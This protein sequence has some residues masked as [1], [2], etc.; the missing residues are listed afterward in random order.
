MH[1]ERRNAS[2]STSITMESSELFWASTSTKT[3]TLAHFFLLSPVS[4][5]Q[6]RQTLTSFPK[7]LEPASFTK[8]FVKNDESVLKLLLDEEGFETFRASSRHDTSS[9]VVSFIGKTHAGKSHLGKELLLKGGY[10]VATGLPSPSSGSFASLEPTTGDCRFFQGRNNGKDITILDMEGEDAGDELPSEV[11]ESLSSSTSEK[12]YCAARR[13]ATREH[14]PRLAYAVSDVIVY[15]TT[16]S[17]SQNDVV[18][19]LERIALSCTE[20]VSTGLL[21]ALVVVQNKQPG[22]DVEEWLQQDPD[23]TILL[24]SWLRTH[25]GETHIKPFFSA[26]KVL[27]ISAGGKRDK[28]LYDEASGKFCKVVEELLDQRTSIRSSRSLVLTP[29]I[30]IHMFSNIVHSFHVAKGLNVD[31]FYLNCILLD[32]G[33]HASLLEKVV[34]LHTIVDSRAKSKE[35]REFLCCSLALFLAEHV[36]EGRASLPNLQAHSVKIVDQ[37]IEKSWTRFMKYVWDGWPCLAVRDGSERCSRNRALHDPNNH[38]PEAFVAV[39]TDNWIVSV[40]KRGIRAV[41]NAFVSWPGAFLSEDFESVEAMSSWCLETYFLPTLALAKRD[42]VFDKHSINLQRIVLFE[43]LSAAKDRL[44][45]MDMGLGKMCLFCLKPNSESLVCH[46]RVCVDCREGFLK[47]NDEC[48]C[49][50]CIVIDRSSV[51]MSASEEMSSRSEP[52]SKQ[53]SAKQSSPT[54]AL[55]PV[56]AAGSK[57]PLRKQRSREMPP[58]PNVAVKQPL[59]KQAG[60]AP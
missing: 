38:S 4:C 25:S 27:L 24:K 53:L 17:L 18:R 58:A 49:L 1:R 37:F 10:D 26:V 29:R 5:S 34:R 57:Q 22:D 6:M 2:I 31:Q 60:K 19:D 21:P 33:E 36:L 50:I 56:K 40:F 8:S 51:E 7:D 44:I 16:G 28:A 43:K 35:I 20:G 13:G 41:K 54:P 32:S 45:T 30:W 39:Q 12:E 11:K 59:K 55:A 9:R 52:P 23:N 3:F 42:G 46:H 47:Q 15:V 14:L 48:R